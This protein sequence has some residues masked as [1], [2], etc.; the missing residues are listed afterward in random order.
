MESLWSQV[1]ILHFLRTPKIPFKQSK[2]SPLVILITLAGVTAFTLITFTNAAAV[3]GLTR[4]PS[5]YFAFLAV[6]C[7]TYMLLA[8]VIKHLY[9]KKYNELL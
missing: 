2:P 8:S 7:V 4:M 6:V 3:F 9:L 1:L 5:G